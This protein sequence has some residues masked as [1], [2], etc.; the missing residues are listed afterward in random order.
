MQV[1]QPMQL[2]TKGC[3]TSTMMR[4][5]FCIFQASLADGQIHECRHIRDDLKKN[6]IQIFPKKGF[7]S[8]IHPIPQP[9]FD[10]AVQFNWRGWGGNGK[11]SKDWW[12]ENVH[13][14]P[15]LGRNWE[16]YPLCPRD[17][18]RPS[19]FPSTLKTSLDPRDFPRPSRFPITF[20]ILVQHRYN[21]I[22]SFKIIKFG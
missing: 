11:V 16:I 12:W 21:P 19:R 14:P 9:Y 7:G 8:P 20:L 22:E 3:L 17:F 10:C 6:W 15:K 2:H 1:S 5:L 4:M 13:T 18:P